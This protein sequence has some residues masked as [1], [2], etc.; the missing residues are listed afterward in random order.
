MGIITAGM[1][2]DDLHTPKFFWWLVNVC[3]SN[4]RLPQSVVHS[5]VEICHSLIHVHL[6]DEYHTNAFAAVIRKLISHIVVG[7][8]CGSRASEF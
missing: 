7:F 3:M 2:Q 5:T 8:N 1:L 4:E 6:A